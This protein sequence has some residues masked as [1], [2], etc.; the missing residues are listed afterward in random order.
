MIFLKI[1]FFKI[2]SC[3]LVSVILVCSFSLI[4]LAEEDE[5]I[6]SIDSISYDNSFSSSYDDYGVSLYS[7]DVEYET[8][9][10]SIDY[11]KI[12][13]QN[14]DSWRI[15]SSSNGSD[16]SFRLGSV[17]NKGNLLTGQYYINHNGLSNDFST[18]SQYLVLNMISQNVFFGTGYNITIDVDV[19]T[20]YL[21]QLV[22]QLTFDGG[23]YMNLPLNRLE[24]NVDVTDS[25]VVN[26]G[27]TLNSPFVQPT[28]VTYEYVLQHSFEFDGNYMLTGVNLIGVRN[29]HSREI[30]YILND[31]K[32]NY[33]HTE[34]KVDVNISIWEKLS[35]F[36]GSFTNFSRNILSSVSSGL[37]NVI[38]NL[39]SVFDSVGNILKSS[40]ESVG[41]AIVSPIKNLGQHINDWFKSTY[42]GKVLSVTSEMKKTINNSGDVDYQSLDDNGSYSD[43]WDMSENPDFYIDID[44]YRELYG[45]D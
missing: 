25:Q 12:I 8:I 37:S 9:Y 16:W 23:Y 6:K 14:F 28:V 5:N 10:N 7:D 17:C 42:L 21:E 20:L 32:F 13:S 22:L 2:I 1:K 18:P 29:F 26:S 36:F 11:K 33:S 44:Y 3:F 30:L 4:A 15:G 31:F 40:F 34:E 27:I 45:G 19:Q 24:K 39:S 38:S 41:N 35:R 43:D